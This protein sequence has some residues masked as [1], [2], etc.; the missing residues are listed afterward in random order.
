VKIDQTRRN[1]ASGPSWRAIACAVSIGLA[2]IACGGGGASGG[3]DPLEVQGIALPSEVS[4][5]SAKSA[6][7]NTASAHSV[8]SEFEPET[9]AYSIATLPDDSDFDSAAVRKFVEVRALE[10][11][12]SLADIF[13]AMR[14]T[15]YADNV[16]RGWYKALV[17]FRD[18]GADGGNETRLEEWYVDSAMV[19]DGTGDQVNRVRIKILEDDR[20]EQ[21]LIRAQLDIRT[22]PTPNED[23]SLADLGEWTIRASFSSIDGDDTAGHFMAQATLLSSGFSQVTIQESF[24]EDPDGPGPVPEMN[25]GSRG[26]I[27]RSPTAGHGVIEFVDFDFC[28]QP[29]NDCSVDGP[30]LRR[31]AFAYNDNYLTIQREDADPIS[32]DRNDDHE[33]AHRYGLFDGVTGETVEKSHR[34]GFPVRT[35]DGAHGWY[36]VWQGRHDLW[37][38]GDSAAGGMTVTREDVR[39]GETPPSYSTVRF[40]GALTKVNLVPGRVDQ[41]LGIPAEAHVWESVRLRWNATEQRWDEC[42]GSDGAG[43]CATRSDFTSRL[44]TLEL[45][46]EADQRWININGC[47]ETGPGAFNCDNF[48]YVTAAP[49]PGFFEATFDEETGRP[50]ST[51]AMLDTSQIPDNMELWAS[52][53][54]RVYI[55]YT[56]EFGGPTTQTGWVQKALTAFDTETWTPSFDPAGDREFLFEVGR[57]YFVNKRGSNLRVRRV[58]ATGEASDYAVFMETHSVATPATDLAEV[59]TPGT[60]LVNA[61]DPDAGSKF[62]LNMNVASPNYLLLEYAD[63]SSQDAQDGRAVGDVVD[64]DRWGLRIEGDTSPIEAATTYNWEYRRSGERWGGVTYLTEQVGQERVYVLLDEALRF[65]PIALPTTDDLVQGRPEDEWLSYSLS[66]DGWL[67]GVPDPWHELQKIG[68]DPEAIPAVLAGNVRLEDGTVLTEVETGRP[69]AVKALDVGIFLG[70]VDDMPLGAPDLSQADGIDLDSDLPDYTAPEM[71]SSIPTNATLL[72]VE[73]VPVD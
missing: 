20:G 59:Y 17:A 73:G 56:G 69:Y 33:L 35:A 2:S 23:G 50:E 10:M 13:D 5:V 67:H 70:V 37:L 32:F 71:S 66:Y 16:G 43:G 64:V 60:V 6:T 63:V 44:P 38:D 21:R 52:I 47:I 55:E 54:G 34:F 25:F 27:V 18:G 41:L 36:G 45:G 53:G 14:Q 12:S 26:L 15:H 7:Q 46:G 30:P 11:F 4:A 1:P 9:S 65:E 58:A 19:S 51:G 48:V 39:G 72:Y 49:G 31:V 29:G 28:W 3:G 40:E 8:W 24:P 42:L 22:A 68:F 57:E 62:R 61:W